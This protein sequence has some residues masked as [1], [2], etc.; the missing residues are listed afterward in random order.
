MAQVP[1]TEW[2][3]VSWTDNQGRQGS[4][5]YYLPSLQK[6]EFRGNGGNDSLVNMTNPNG[7]RQLPNVYRKR[8]RA[9]HSRSSQ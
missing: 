1:I 4:G 9:S 3:I 7:N 6:I 8:I 5:R 2:L